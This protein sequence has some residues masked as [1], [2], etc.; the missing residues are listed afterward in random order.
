[1]VTYQPGRFATSEVPI[2]VQPERIGVP[3]VHAGRPEWL[4]LFLYRLLL[5]DLLLWLWLWLNLRL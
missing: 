3:S 2:L 5:R 1:M 4:A